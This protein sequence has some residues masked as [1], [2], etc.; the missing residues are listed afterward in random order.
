MDDKEFKG[1]FR[2]IFAEHPK[3]NKAVEFVWWDQFKEL[4]RDEFMAVARKLKKTHTYGAPKVADC[5]AVL[6]Q[7]RQEAAPEQL[8][9]T[10]QEALIGYDSDHSE[11]L[12]AAREFADRAAPPIPGDRQ[13]ESPEELEKANRIQRAV[14]ERNFKEHY[15][16]LAQK[17]KRLIAGGTEPRIAISEVSQNQTSLDPDVKAI[18]SGLLKSI[19]DR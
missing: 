6:E 10:G 5:W 13:F 3:P 11:L 2:Y 7:T 12:E 17:A 8:D 19:P 15:E 4:T 18:A 9:W 14:W 16:S 1:V